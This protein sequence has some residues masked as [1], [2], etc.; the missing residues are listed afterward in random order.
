MRLPGSEDSDGESG[1]HWQR[2][3]WRA[4]NE[5]VMTRAGVEMDSL[6]EGTGRLDEQLGVVR[7]QQPPSVIAFQPYTSSLAV[8]TRCEYSKAKSSNTRRVRKNKGL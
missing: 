6:D 1:E 4:R 5:R 3:W 8:A 2:E 7:L